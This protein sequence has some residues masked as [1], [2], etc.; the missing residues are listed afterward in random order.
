MP[1]SRIP[2]LSPAS[3]WSSNLRNISTPV[4]VVV[5]VSF[6]PTIS[7]SSPTLMMP[8]SIRPVTTVPRPEI[9][10]TSSTGIKK[11]PSTARSGNGMYVSK[12]STN[13][14]TDGTPISDVSPSSALSA[15][16]VTIGVS[17][18]GNSYMSNNSR[19]SISTNSSSSSSSTMSA[20]FK[21]TTMYG[22]PTWRD[23]RICSRV[24][25]IG[26]SA[27]E[28]TKIAPSICAAPVIMFFT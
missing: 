26:P 18:P 25:G 9:E 17:S 11:S 20:L 22:T 21:N 14:S 28:Q 3:P 10:K 19:T 6:T 1:R 27:A 4:Q 23:S 13:F 16:P 12:A 5:T 2:T 7:I 8:R 24:C 15:E